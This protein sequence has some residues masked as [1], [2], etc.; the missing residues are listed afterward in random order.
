MGILKMFLKM[1]IFVYMDL[2]SSVG[3]ESLNDLSQKGLLPWILI[4]LR[5]LSWVA[6]RSLPEWPLPPSSFILL[7]GYTMTADS[8]FRAWHNRSNKSFGINHLE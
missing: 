4:A 3:R 5:L 6:Y 8:V 1:E 7:T 2:V